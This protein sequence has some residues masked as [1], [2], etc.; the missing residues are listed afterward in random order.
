[1]IPQSLFDISQDNFLLD[2]NL[3][4]QQKEIIAKFKEGK[5]LFITGGAGTGK[6]YLLNYLKNNYSKIGLEVTASTGIAAVNV[7]GL[8]IHSW[9]GIGIGTL[10]VEQIV[11]NLFSKNFSRIRRRIQQAKAL[12]IDEISMISAQTFD[13]INEVLKA[14]RQDNRPFG[15]LQIILFGDFLQLP[16]VNR[17][18]NQIDF[19]FNAK[20]WQEL[21]PE[22]CILQKIF[23]QNDE[24]FTKI[25]DNLRFGNLTQ[26]DVEILQTRINAVDSNLAI[27]PTILTTHNYKIEQ[28]N[29]NELNKIPRETISHKATYFGDA[30]KIEFLKKNCL[31]YETLN[32]KVGAQVMMIKNTYQKE[33]IINGS[34]GVVKDFSVKKQH[35]IVEFANGQT[36]TITPQ[37]WTIDR[38]DEEKKEIISEAGI[39]QIPL[40]L[41][42]AITIHKA[43]GLTLDKIRCDLA[44][45]F[46]AGQ[47][48]VALSRVT[49]IQGL[50][51][52]SINLRKITANN[53]AVSFYQKMM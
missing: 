46:S 14:V 38:F 43:Q 41:S 49:S 52:N 18:L 6:S 37:D 30:N 35:P 34:L 28:I 47:V 23:R 22:V 27:K 5:N 29:Q 9:S 13:L 24:G 17:N 25:L 21:N 31:A 2:Q 42:W 3:S 15:N 10:P 40:I 32:L 33:G 8:T 39:T 48:Y 53:D 19:C 44:D 11:R 36:L 7:G 45:V 51:L 1:M 12:A 26:D 4:S 20:A 50:F 16:P